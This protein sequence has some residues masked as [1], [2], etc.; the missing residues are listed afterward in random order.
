MPKQIAIAMAVGGAALVAAS[1]VTMNLPNY[2]N[3][4]P[5]LLIGGGVLLWMGIQKYR[6]AM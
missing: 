1:M 4:F 6:N 5:V 3:S 2:S